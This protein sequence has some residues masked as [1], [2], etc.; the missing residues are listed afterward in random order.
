MARR[1]RGSPRLPVLLGRSGV[2]SG[3]AFVAAARPIRKWRARVAVVLILAAMKPGPWRRSPARRRRWPASCSPSI[4]QPP[5]RVPTGTSSRISSTTPRT[6][7]PTA[8]TSTRCSRR[9]DRAST[10]PCSSTALSW[11]ARRCRRPRWPTGDAVVIEI[12]DGALAVTQRLGEVDSGSRHARLVPRPGAD[13]PPERSDRAGALGS[14]RR[15]ERHRI[16]RG[17]QHHRLAAE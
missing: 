4:R 10:S 5:R 8:R 9:A 7:C 11:P 6:S 13:G 2:A 1:C 12:A 16:R 3:R 14:R 15:L 17:R